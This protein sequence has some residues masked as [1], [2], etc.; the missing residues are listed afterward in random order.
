MKRLMLSVLLAAIVFPVNLAIAE[1][2][3]NEVVA[4]ICPEKE[5]ICE[6]LFL[7][8]DMLG[9]IYR[10]EVAK[11]FFLEGSE[12]VIKQTI[13]LKIKT[14]S[15]EKVVFSPGEFE[16]LYTRAIMDLKQKTLTFELDVPSRNEK[17][18][19]YFTAKHYKNDIWVVS[20]NQHTGCRGA[21]CGPLARN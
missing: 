11:K 21:A 6:F 20:R 8:V 2:T 14:S 10:L 15:V 9:P 3:P 7:K 16:G 5:A 4:S 12:I 13:P 18:T 1:P 17:Y 19:V